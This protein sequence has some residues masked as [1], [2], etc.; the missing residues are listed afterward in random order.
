MIWGLRIAWVLAPVALWGLVDTALTNVNSAFDLTFIIGA[1]LFWLVGL[2]ACLYPHSLSLTLLRIL[3]PLAWAICIWA[4]LADV[5]STAEVILGFAHAIILILICFSTYIGNL[6][7]GAEAYGTEER[8][9]LKSPL[10][11]QCVLAPIVWLASIAG[12][13]APPLLLVNNLW[14][15]GGTILPVGILVFLFG[16]RS[17]HSLVRRQLIF[18]PNGLVVSDPLRLEF[19]IR[20]E[21]K[22]IQSLAIYGANES[23]SFSNPSLSD[24]SF[25]D[26]SQGTLGQNITLQ[27]D[28]PAQVYLLKARKT[29]GD[30]VTDASILRFAITRL[31]SVQKI[32]KRRLK[33]HKT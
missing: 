7:I 5:H 15:W 8:F 25:L 4:V 20:M 16:L 9:L 14:V 23:A 17:L 10:F 21:A 6:F 26:L 33:V 27:L 13:V 29:G 12:L 32:I 2:F 11:I 22:Q 30:G 1:G 19:P 24:L 31:D 18:V 3:A 28:P